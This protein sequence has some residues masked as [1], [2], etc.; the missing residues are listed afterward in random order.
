MKSMIAGGLLMFFVLGVASAGLASAPE[1]TAVPPVGPPEPLADTGKFALGVGYWFAQSVMKF[2]GTLNGQPTL[3]AFSAWSN[4]YYAQ[5]NYT[6][7]KDWEVYARLGAADLR[8]GPIVDLHESGQAW[9]SVGFKGVLY[10]YNNFAVGPLFEWSW[11]AHPGSPFYD[12][13]NVDFGASAQYKLPA[14]RDLTLYGGTLLYWHEA[15]SDLIHNNIGLPGGVPVAGQIKQQQWSNFGE[16][17]G[18]KLPLVKESLFF[19]TE[20]QLTAKMSLG[21]LISYLF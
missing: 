8:V 17:L 4:Q 15:K 2:N 7:L 1:A 6:F 19:M 5:G 9:G 21:V 18:V 14:L 20:A 10:R 11:Y 16:F 12:Q 13:W 3:R